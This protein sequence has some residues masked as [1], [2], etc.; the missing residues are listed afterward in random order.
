M[1]S[2]VKI[3]AA[4]IIDEWHSVEGAY[5]DFPEL[6]VLPPDSIP[7]LKNNGAQ[8]LPDKEKT[9]NLQETNK[10]LHGDKIKE[11]PSSKESSQFIKETVSIKPNHSQEALPEKDQLSLF[12]SQIDPHSKLPLKA[13]NR[14]VANPMKTESIIQFLKAEGITFIDKREQSGIVWALYSEEAK[15]KIESFF[16]KMPMRIVLEKRGSTSTGNKP[17]WRIMIK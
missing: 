16:E 7:A 11:N 4:Q 6:V 8:R 15:S 13:S 1:L 14:I 2:R 5:A 9:I 12:T 10:N 17:A 3:R